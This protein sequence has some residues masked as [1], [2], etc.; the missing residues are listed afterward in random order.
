MDVDLRLPE[1]VDDDIQTRRVQ[2]HVARELWREAEVG[3]VHLVAP[4]PGVADWLPVGRGALLD[5]DLH[6]V[7]GRLEGRHNVPGDLP[8]VLL[9]HHLAYVNIDA[10]RLLHG[11]GPG[12]DGDDT[13]EPSLTGLQLDL[14]RQSEVLLQLVYDGKVREEGH[15]RVVGHDAPVRVSMERVEVV[16]GGRGAAGGLPDEDA[17]GVEELVLLHEDVGDPGPVVAE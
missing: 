11:L 7:L 17:V 13:A 15:R 1:H 9:G 10:V 6:H 2:G 16:R 4:L 14:L 5:Q 12:A 3:D 8:R